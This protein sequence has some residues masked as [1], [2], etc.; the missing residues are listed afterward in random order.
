MIKMILFCSIRMQ[1]MHMN[2]N[3]CYILLSNTYI[4]LLGAHTFKSHI[5]K[6]IKQQI[7]K[8][9][10]RLMEHSTQVMPSCR[11]YYPEKIQWRSN[12]GK[13]STFRIII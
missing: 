6:T 5:E 2:K 1:T 9:R 8:E 10:N 7:N 12:L 4:V 13:N 3:S 11:K